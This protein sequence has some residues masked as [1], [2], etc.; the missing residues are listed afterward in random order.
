M[1]YCIFLFTHYN[2]KIPAFC[3]FKWELHFQKFVHFTHEKKRSRNSST[4]HVQKSISSFTLSHDFYL[5]FTLQ[6][7]NGISF[8]IKMVH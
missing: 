3:G 1:A 8:I 6:E 2:R 7:N 5:S 4:A